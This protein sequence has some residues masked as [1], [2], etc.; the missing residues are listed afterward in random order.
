[1]NTPASEHEVHETITIDVF[2]PNHPPRKESEL[3]RRTKNHLIAIMDAPCWVCGAMQNRE[4]HH[5]H[6]EWADADGIDW[7]KMRI[8]HPN[9]PWSTFKES[10]DFIDSEYNM[11]VLC[12]KHHRGKDHGI[13]VLPYPIWIMQR[14]QRADFIFSPDEVK[15]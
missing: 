9:F 14:D 6:A 3:F 5:F 15:A 12:E 1:M 11:M 4:V 13:H 10:T 2:Y 8:L 7:D